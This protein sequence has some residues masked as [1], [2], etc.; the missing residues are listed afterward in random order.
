[1]LV[2]V[3]EANRTGNSHPLSTA[4]PVKASAQHSVSKNTTWK[5]PLWQTPKPKTLGIKEHSTLAIAAGHR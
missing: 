1:M 4:K 2:I 5:A 3:T